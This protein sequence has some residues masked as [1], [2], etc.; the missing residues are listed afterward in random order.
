MVRVAALTIVASLIVLPLTAQ[1]LL[2]NPG[3][4]NTDQ[5]DDWTCTISNGVASWSAEDLFGSTTSGSMRHDVSAGSDNQTIVCR[6]CVPVVELNAYVPSMWFFW[7]DNPAFSQLGSSRISYNYYSD[8]T[9]SAYL[10]PG[11][12]EAPNPAALDTWLYLHADETVAPP[13]SQSA[14]VNLVTWQNF[15]GQP[16]RAHIDD[17]DFRTTTIFRDGFESGTTNAWEP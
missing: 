13:G 14:M 7:P 6:Q 11:D 15:A 10:G 5:L 1:N 3:F 17:V 2:V 12:V 9:C 16:V 8:A 4:D